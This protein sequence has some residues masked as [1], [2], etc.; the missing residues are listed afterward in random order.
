M[1]H[2]L[3]E[4]IFPQSINSVFH[5]PPTVLHFRNKKSSSTAMAAGHTFTIEPIVCMGDS[6]P[7][8][9]KDGWTVSTKDNS[10]CAQFEH[11]ILITEN[12]AECLTAKTESSPKYFWE[13]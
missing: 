11:T 9:W 4:F 5:G 13:T 3:R 12:G 1:M 8:F 7:I 2:A 10:P 6:S